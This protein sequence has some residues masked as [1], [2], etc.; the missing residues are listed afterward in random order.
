MKDRYYLGVDLGSVS[1]DAVILDRQGEIKWWKYHRIHGWPKRA[2]YILSREIRDEFIIPNNIE[3]FHGSLATGSGKEIVK[4]VLGLEVINEIIAHGV[5]AARTAGSR[6]SVIEIGGQDSKFINADKNGPYDYSMNELCAAGTGAFLDVQAERLGLSIEVFSELASSAKNVPSV[7]GRCSVFAKSDLIHLQ[8]RG[9]PNGEIVAGLCYA[10][11]RNYL[12]TMIKGREVIKPVVFQG[13]VALNDGVIRAFKDL[14]KLEDK[15]IIRPKLPHMMGAVGAALISMNE[16][17]KDNTAKQISNLAKKAQDKAAKGIS[18]GGWE[19]QTAKPDQPAGLES[20]ELNRDNKGSQESLFLGIDIGSVSTGA[21]LINPQGGIEARAYTFTAG[22]PLSAVKKV[23]EFLKGNF[24]RQQI[25]AVGTTGSGRKLVGYLIG[26]DVIVDEIT[27]QA[28]GAYDIM[29]NLDTVIEIGGQDAKFITLDSDGLVKDFE[30]NK[31]C[32][33]GTGSFIQEQAVR[34][35]VD[36]KNEFADLAL[37][38]ESPLPLTS[39]CTVFMESDLVHHIQQNTRLPDLLMGVANAVVENYLDRVALGRKPGKNVLIQGGVAKNA[40]V[41]KAFKARLSDSKIE[42]HPVP[43]LSGALGIAKLAAEEA[44]R[45]KMKSSFTGFSLE[46][47]YSS[48][49]FNCLNCENQCEV[50][51]FDTLSGRFYFGDLCGR[52]GES[53]FSTDSG[54]DHTQQREMLLR[55]MVESATG[56]RRMGIP[57]ALLFREY[58]PFW[59]SFFS[60]LGIKIV[61]SGRSTSVKLNAGLARLPAETC[62]PIKLLFGHVT[63]LCN[64][65]IK[66]IFLPSFRRIEN[67]FPCPYVQH[68]AA[69]ISS[70]FRDCEILSFSLLPDIKGRN[71][72]LLL[73]EIAG[74]F[75][76]RRDQVEAAY[77]QAQKVYSR[78]RKVTEIKPGKSRSVAVIIG[79]PYNAADRFV[80]LALSSKL[81]RAGFE[82]VLA[83]QLSRVDEVPLPE[84]YAK[85]DWF[86][87]RKMLASAMA[88]KKH[89]NYF[90]VVV[91]NFGCGPD[92]FT[93]PLLDEIADG[94]P[95]L[96]LEVDEHRADAGLDTRIEA[97]SECVKR[98]RELNTRRD[99][100]WQGR[101]RHVPI[102][103]GDPVKGKKTYIIPQFSD[104]AFAFAG[105]FRGAGGEARVLPLPDREVL[106]LG[107]ELSGG[108]ECHPF[109]LIAGDIMRLARTGGLPWGAVYLFPVLS[110]SS[111]LISQYVPTIER[112]LSD[113]GRSDVTVIG[114]STPALVEHFGRWFIL[115]LG[116]G[117]AGIEYM[118][119][120]RYELRPYEVIKG[121]VDAA[122][123]RALDIIVENLA[124]GRAHDG[125]ID[126]VFEMEKVKTRN[127]GTKP[128]IG[129]AGDV[130]TRVNPAANGGLFEIL[131]ELGCEVWLAPTILD[132]ALS[133]TELS[134]K[135]HW[136][137]REL[138]EMTSSWAK[139]VVGKMELWR[140]EKHFK[141]L[142]RNFGE[143]DMETIEKYVE[144]LL[145][146]EPELLVMLNVAKHVDFA[147]KG[148]DGILNVFCLNCMVGTSTAAV[149]PSIR[150][151]TGEIPMMSLVFD[152]LGTTHARNRT[153]AF[154][155]RVKRYHKE[156]IEKKN[157]KTGA[158]EKGLVDRFME[159]LEG[160][161]SKY[162]LG[163]E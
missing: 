46:S 45:K 149:F 162:A 116:R 49:T 73:D 93:L 110:G 105:A 122:Y 37:S 130:Y 160:L 144:D 60:K 112:Y 106:E 62:L 120:L 92:A 108:R 16:P 77:K 42:V 146:G 59:F 71:L 39:R 17:Q 132:V 154:A 97:F 7:A 26:A 44:E 5:A 143:P 131:E 90:P 56:R 57:E 29:K 157:R 159:T 9:I 2:I 22:R 79:K 55:E 101:K 134:V 86:F 107:V 27:S 70:V 34:L 113:I 28:V 115:N 8:Q 95:S 102:S 78:Y 64:K 91:T 21:M 15:E 94:K 51:T 10:L 137:Q 140:V 35:S 118:L 109:K 58:F 23:F 68:A 100:S 69:M 150:E 88:V 67:N 1:L 40:A 65:K 85:I 138:L 141:G 84:R 82:V 147:E 104:H 72:K 14:L 158:A 20:F 121:E 128:A 3:K 136:R 80:N 153:E 50:N 74:E 89:E 148:V 129:V 25:K 4:K 135:R 48:S 152:G 155:H 111:C 124:Q 6:T 133:G 81:A 19:M 123:H 24:K 43:E 145:P 30:M 61:T 53:S 96:F 32:S 103:K 163:D 99:L 75:A 54:K 66:T 36:L 119:R 87:N 52:Y 12:A 139:G 127:K 117:I 47:D 126:A 38:A 151:K 76:V 11:A 63:E 156:R 125:I 13:G 114:T 83:D 142:L 33:A 31:I 161:R 18:L 98:W 41:V